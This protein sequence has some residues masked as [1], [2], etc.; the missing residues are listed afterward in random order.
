MTPPQDS[1]PQISVGDL[2]V[3]TSGMVTSPENKPITIDLAEN[4]EIEFRFHFEGD[5]DP[6][7]ETEIHEDKLV[8]NLHNFQSG[9]VMGGSTPKIGLLEPLSI[10][11]IYERELLLLF[12][13]SSSK[14]GDTA[15]HSTLYYN[16]Y[17][18]E[19]LEGESDVGE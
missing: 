11:T 15:A 2:D 19:E 13:V 10:G 5:S 9:V 6:S 7:V 14:S 4:I 8:V 17:L 1:R 16:F 12:E 3:L 18:G